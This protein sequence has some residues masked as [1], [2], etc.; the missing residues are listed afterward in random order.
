MVDPHFFFFALP[1]KN[2]EAH[3]QAQVE[4]EL[5]LSNCL[6]SC[7]SVSILSLVPFLLELSHLVSCVLAIG[8][9]IIKRAQKIITDYEPSITLGCALLEIIHLPL[10][11][12]ILVS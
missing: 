1:D 12:S 4:N 11:V 2:Q 9:C 5:I 7:F 6:L 3:M 10:K 8:T